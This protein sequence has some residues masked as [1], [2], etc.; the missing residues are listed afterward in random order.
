QQGLGKHAVLQV[1]YVGSNGHKLY[2]FRDINQPSQDAIDQADL[3]CNCITSIR[4]FNNGFPFNFFYI[5]MQES[6]G[7][8]TYNS[9]QSSLKINNWHGLTSTVN[10]TWSHSIDDSSDG[11][12]FVQNAAQP[13]D[14]TKPFNNRGNSNFDVRNRFT[15]NFIYE[16]PN[17]HG[18][19]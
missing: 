12:D 15:W 3:A 5:Y 6:S 7:N 17:R 9:L 13:T 11:E 16:F 2:R 14:S 1:G 4:N 18:S 8:S 10:Y 19:Y